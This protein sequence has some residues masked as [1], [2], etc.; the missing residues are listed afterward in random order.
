[1]SRLRNVLVICSLLLL[2]ACS[3]TTFFYNRLDFFIPWYLDDYVD[4]NREQDRYLDE[5]LEPFLEWH[6]LEELPQY[7]LILQDIETRIDQP[8]TVEDVEAVAVEM[9]D[10]WF[11]LQD[12]F[13]EWLLALGAQLSDEQVDEFTAYLWNRQE[14]Y[15]DKYLERSEKEFRDDSYDS[16]LDSVQDYTGR[17]GKEQ[18]ALLRQASEELVRSDKVWLTERAAWLKKLEVMMQRE[19]GWQQ[20]VRDAVAQRSENLSSEYRDTY[21]HNMRVIY[22]AVAEVLNMRSERQDLHLRRELSDLR[23]DLETLIAQGLAQDEAA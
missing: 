17:L 20:R 9:E 4:L 15:E 7:V 18:R 16:L 5:L 11:R 12:E 14:K 8:L 3:G 19:P 2:G 22:A 1:M 23:E 10:A 6:R 21:A 13:L